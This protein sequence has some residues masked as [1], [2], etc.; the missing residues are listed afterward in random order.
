MDEVGTPS[1]TAVT[2]FEVSATKGKIRK[3]IKKT[4]DL[5]KKKKKKKTTKKTKKTPLKR[6]KK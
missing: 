6:K 1:T 3:P 4:T 2:L 5:I